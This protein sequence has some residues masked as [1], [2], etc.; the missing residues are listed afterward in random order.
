MP[1]GA[2]FTGAA[3][4][5]LIQAA[6]GSILAI[7]MLGCEPRLPRTEGFL[8]NGFLRALSGP[9]RLVRTRSGAAGDMGRRAAASAMPTYH[10]CLLDARGRAEEILAIRAA[11]DA[12]AQ[13]K[14]IAHMAGNAAFSGFELW[15]EGRLVIKY[16]PT[17]ERAPEGTGKPVGRQP[18]ARSAA[19][20][21]ARRYRSGRA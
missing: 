3:S 6:R 20:A 21:V 2:F 12:E 11:D 7:A 14:A 4:W 19:K 9:A 18:R 13:Q 5:G 15:N 17:L 10:C 1:S 16:T 8:M